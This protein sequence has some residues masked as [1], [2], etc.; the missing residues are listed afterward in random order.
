[1]R[2]LTTCV[3]GCTCLYRSSDSLWQPGQHIPLNV[4]VPE[5]PSR[6]TEVGGIQSPEATTSVVELLQTLQ[7]SLDGQFTQ[8]NSTLVQIS[9]RLN[10]LEDR[11]RSIEDKIETSSSSTPQSSSSESGLIRK[12]RTPVAL[13]VFSY[14]YVCFKLLYL[15]PF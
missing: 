12:R 3:Y 6:N 4:H 9:D 5:T 7:S 11:Q 1:M 8:I 10:I 15:I 14:N 2:P 13:Q